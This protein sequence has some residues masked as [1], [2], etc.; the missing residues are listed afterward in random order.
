MA[1]EPA[2]PVDSSARTVLSACSESQGQHNFRSVRCSAMSNPTH[3]EESEHCGLV[4][5]DTLDVVGVRV[6]L[7]EPFQRPAPVTLK[8]PTQAPVCI[9]RLRNILHIGLF[10]LLVK[11]LV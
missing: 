11:V 9:N 5:C 7:T 1:T 8:V 6:G 2:G 10:E 4:E 3:F